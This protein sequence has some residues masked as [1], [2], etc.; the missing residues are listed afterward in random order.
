MALPRWL[1]A[2]PALVGF[3]SM[4]ALDGCT[5]MADRDACSRW[6]FLDG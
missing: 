2:M 6:L 4:P 1:L 5:S 3:T